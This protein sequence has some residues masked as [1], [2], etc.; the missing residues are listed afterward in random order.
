MQQGQF[1]G[2]R[3]RKSR[4]G[5]SALLSAA[6]GPVREQVFQLLDHVDHVLWETARWGAQTPASTF[7]IA[8][9]LDQYRSPKR[10]LCRN[11]NRCGPGAARRRHSDDER[12][13]LRLSSTEGGGDSMLSKW[14]GSSFSL[15]VGGDLRQLRALLLHAIRFLSLP[16]N[17]NFRPLHSSST[18]CLSKNITTRPRRQ[19]ITHFP[20]A[21][22]IQ[23]RGKNEPVIERILYPLLSFLFLHVISSDT[24]YI[25]QS[26]CDKIK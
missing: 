10:V 11:L 4:L 17:C 15:P 3:K 25:G 21:K 1:G 12:V 6:C 19:H 9:F 23:S 18:S 26:H 8:I 14:R 24:R 16:S 13:L 2:C 7:R 20:Y 5:S 22:N